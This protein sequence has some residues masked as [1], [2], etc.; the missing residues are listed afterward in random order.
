MIFGLIEKCWLCLLSVDQLISWTYS[1]DVEHLCSVF[2]WCTHCD[3]RAAAEVKQITITLCCQKVYCCFFTLPV[4]VMETQSAIKY[5]RMWNVMFCQCQARGSL[6]YII[7]NRLLC[8]TLHWMVKVL[9]VCIHLMYSI[10]CFFSS[11]ADKTLF[12]ILYHT[13]PFYTIDY[14]S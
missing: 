8:I 3:V 6:P 1:H 11:N 9:E 5:T 7:L 2:K 13:I 12:T 10:I 14:E 4:T